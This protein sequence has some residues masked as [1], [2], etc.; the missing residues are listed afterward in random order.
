M[1]IAGMIML[2]LLSALPL[3]AQQ[4]TTPPAPTA[5]P[6]PGTDEDASAAIAALIDGQLA[7]F[8]AR[9]V[10]GAWGAASAN[11]QRLF[12]NPQQFGSMVQQAYPMVWD[13]ANARFISQRQLD[14]YVLQ[15][16][17]IEDAQGVL[18]LLEYAMIQTDAGWRIDGVALLPQPDVGV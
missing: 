11:I 10:D 18:H 2:M 4:V 17:M 6:V 3:Q 13:N 8:K 5:A 12:G 9:D 15:Q 7:D 1:R 16:V 14:A